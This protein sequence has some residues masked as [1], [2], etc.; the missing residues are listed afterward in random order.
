MT[1]FALCPDLAGSYSCLSRQ[2]KLGEIIQKEKRGVTTYQIKMSDGQDFE[3]IADGNLRDLPD[4]PGMVDNTL[5]VDCFENKIE[6]E[7]N[8][9]A[10]DKKKVVGP[11][12]YQQIFEALDDGLLIKTSGNFLGSAIPEEQ[13][14][15]IRL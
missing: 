9:N 3:Y 13:E 1:S 5:K 6:V 12:S 15:C 10:A 14:K 11:V 7:T 4:T 8:S 2:G